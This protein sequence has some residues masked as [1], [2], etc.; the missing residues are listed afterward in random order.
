MGNAEEAAFP[1]HPMFPS[2]CSIWDLPVSLP[3]MTM[4]L[5]FS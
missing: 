5:P 3:G 2:S 1:D 4:L